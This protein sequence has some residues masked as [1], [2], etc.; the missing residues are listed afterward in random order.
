MIG[1]AERPFR[2]NIVVA[3][4]PIVVFSEGTIPS[5]LNGY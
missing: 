5:N 1:P 4:V 2:Y 3:V